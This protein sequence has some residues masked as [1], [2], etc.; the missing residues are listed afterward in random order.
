MSTI[1]LALRL[2]AGARKAVEAVLQS[3]ASG[4]WLQQDQRWYHPK[5][6]VPERMAVI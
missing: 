6:L 1:V 5:L 2:G 4:V 3:G